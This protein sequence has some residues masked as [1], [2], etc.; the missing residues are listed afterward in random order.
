ML[1]I[2]SVGVFIELHPE[3]TE[4]GLA[5]EQ[6]RNDVENRLRRVDIKVLPAKESLILHLPTLVISI[7]SVK[8]KS[9]G[10]YA[11]SIRITLEQDVIAVGNMLN[12]MA[13]T[14]SAPG[15]TGLVKPKNL[16]KVRDQIENQVDHFIN[17]HLE[18]NAK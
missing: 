7:G 12:V 1:G 8:E 10:I 3:L 5:E 9:T 18:M 17:D 6:I 14:W 13:T 15:A 4:D 2:T 16:R 11:I